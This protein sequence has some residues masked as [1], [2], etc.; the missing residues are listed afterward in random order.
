MWLPDKRHNCLREEEREDVSVDILPQLGSRAL[1]ENTL[2]PSGG[3]REGAR[4]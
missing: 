2:L 3:D 4:C 1:M